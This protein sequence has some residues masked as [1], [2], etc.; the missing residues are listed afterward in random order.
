M[1]SKQ[2]TSCRSDHTTLRCCLR[3]FLGTMVSGNRLLK[4]W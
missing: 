1:S 4:L 3:M 2:E